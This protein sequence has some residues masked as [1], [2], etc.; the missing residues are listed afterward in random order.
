MHPGLVPRRQ[1]DFLIS[2]EIREHNAILSRIRD[3][4]RE[5]GGVS[6]IAIGYP[7]VSRLSRKRAPPHRVR[8]VC[9]RV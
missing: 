8:Q 7:T 4:N 6:A 3:T 5:M 2:F 1:P 9:R